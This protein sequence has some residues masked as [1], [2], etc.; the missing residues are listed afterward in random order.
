MCIKR[1]NEFRINN[2]RKVRGHPAYIYKKE[3]NEYY[4]VGITH[5]EITDRT[6]NIRLDRNPNKND[7]RPSYARPYASKDN[8]SKFGSKKKKWKLSRKDKKK[9]KIIRKNFR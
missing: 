5:S 4:F 9:M 2:S 6:K 1:R 7:P 3:D 8:V